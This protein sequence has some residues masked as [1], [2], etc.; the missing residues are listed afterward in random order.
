MKAILHPSFLVQDQDL[1]PERPQRLHAFSHLQT[2]SILSGEPYLSLVHEA[3][4]LEQ[5]RAQAKVRKALDPDT[6]VSPERYQAALYA[7]GASIQASEEQGFAVLRPPGHHAFPDH[8]AGFCLFNNVAIASEKLAREGKRVLIFDFDGHHAD[9]TSSIFYERPDVMVWS[10]HQSPAYPG[11]GSVEE[12]GSKAGAGYTVN[13][14]LPPH[15]GDDVFM[16]AF[17]TFLPVAEQFNPDVLAI[18][19]GFDGHLFD[20]I[21]QMRLSVGTYHALGVQLQ[22]H[23]PRLFGVLEGGYNTEYLS[24]CLE[25]FLAGLRNEAA[26][27]TEPETD[28]N[29]IVWNEY[30]TRLHS[31]IEYHQ[32]HWKF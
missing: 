30:E 9:G 4:Y 2:S 32:T 6:P 13:L 1:H 27:Y 21:L 7:V 3:A 15:S 5:V 14:P 26:P 8:G 10:I 11:T 31:A 25:N 29:M 17:R 12:L 23:F 18:S 20:G 28:S 16:D 24:K 22:G 19:A